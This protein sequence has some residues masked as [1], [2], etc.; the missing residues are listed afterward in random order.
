ML[1]ELIAKL[2]DPHS[3]PKK[4]RSSRPYQYSVRVSPVKERR[5]ALPHPRNQIRWTQMYKERYLLM[6]HYSQRSKWSLR[7]PKKA[8]SRT[9]VEN[10]NQNVHRLKLFASGVDLDSEHFLCRHPTSFFAYRG[11]RRLHKFFDSEEFLGLERRYPVLWML[12][13][14]NCFGSIYTH[15]VSWAV[16]SKDVVKQHIEASAHTFGGAIDREMRDAN[17][18]ETNGILIGPE[19]SR[20]FAEII[21]QDVDT[22]AAKFMEKRRDHLLGRFD[23]RRY[24]D[25]YF[26]F[27][28]NDVVAAEV[29]EVIA[30]E[31]EAYHL[32]INSKKT[33]KL[34]RPFITDRSA[35]IE[36]MKGPLSAFLDAIS[37]RSAVGND[38]GV[39]LEML[40][41]EEV[42]GLPAEVKEPSPK[43]V[44]VPKDIRSVQRVKAAFLKQ[45]RAVCRGS[46]SGY[47]LVT[48]YLIPALSNHLIRMCQVEHVSVDDES[49]YRRC[50]LLLVEVVF[51]LYAVSPSV[52]HSAR[53]AS[54]FLLSLSFLGRVDLWNVRHAVEEEVFRSA[55]AFLRESWEVRPAMQGAGLETL[56]VVT[57]IGQLGTEFEIPWHILKLWV[58]PKGCKLSKLDYFSL[59]TLARYCG[60][61][62]GYEAAVC[63]VEQAISERVR[64]CSKTDMEASSE[65]I[66]LTLDALSCPHFSMDFRGK[67][68][69]AIVAKLETR[70]PKANAEVVGAVQWLQSHPWFSDWQDVSL[71]RSLERRQRTNVY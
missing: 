49:K 30:V 1:E 71:F 61:R 16:K 12:D 47:D 8:G 70:R 38:P 10:S 20:I 48:G 25:D 57:L 40:S 65:I 22:K 41:D 62:K 2:L 26:I 60:N 54:S 31:L 45:V 17:W 64:N 32:S 69:K 18:A 55:T 28:A 15:S 36:R 35:A 59:V 19:L 68:L 46:E 43:F 66:H 6:V 27:A 3:N 33:T 63:E 51:F 21:L 23:V 53:L 52:D 37:I 42:A 39:N 4:N 24:V 7:A 50:I 34:A 58:V 44:I 5:L 56:N 13:I 14:S 67:L 9:F 29:A 11:Y